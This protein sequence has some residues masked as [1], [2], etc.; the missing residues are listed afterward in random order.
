M[1][2][3]TALPPREGVGLSMVQLWRLLA[4][5]REV[6]RASYKRFCPRNIL[7]LWYME[8]IL[9]EPDIEFKVCHL[10][11]LGATRSSLPSV[12]THASTASCSAPS[13]P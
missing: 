5:T 2:H 10:S 13:S 1:P 8:G 6:L 9:K 3:P 11:D 7:R 4:R 12:S